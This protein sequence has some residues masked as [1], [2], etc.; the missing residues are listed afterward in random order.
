MGNE[1]Y[2]FKLKLLDTGYFKKQSGKE[3][4]CTCPFCGKRKHCYVLFDLT[5][6][7]PLLYNCFRCNSTGIVNRKFLEYFNLEEMDIPHVKTLRKIDIANKISSTNKVVMFNIDDKKSIK[8]FQDYIKYRVNIEPTVDEL[9]QFQLMTDPDLYARDYLGE[10]SKNHE[11]FSQAIWFR[12]ANGNIHGRSLYSDT[13]RWI[14][15]SSRRIRDV[16]IYNIKNGFDMEQDIIVCIC[17]GIIDAIGL[18]YYNKLNGIT[19]C[20]YIACCG[21]NYEI[22]LKQAISK[23]IFGNSVSVRIYK[24]SDVDAKRIHLDENRV[25]LFKSVA[26]YENTKAHDYGVPMDSID[27]K[28]VINI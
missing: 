6:D 8:L 28:K 25:K 12:L 5:N 16:G 2:E 18:Y 26:I 27:V 17:E 10:A 23:G 22:G 20:I 7:T 21:K 13:E 19:N 24:D 1:L 11:W 3:Y 15:F 14:K 9:M 4:V